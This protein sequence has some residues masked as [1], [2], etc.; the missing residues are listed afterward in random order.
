[1]AYHHDSSDSQ[2]FEELTPRQIVARLDEYI[3]GQEA[4]K[5]AIAVPSA[6]AC[7]GCASPASYATR[8]SP[9]T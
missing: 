4:A 9:R 1:M 5:R 7:A 3:V 2:R 6:T 8:S